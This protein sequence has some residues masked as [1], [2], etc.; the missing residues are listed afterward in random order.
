MTARRRLRRWHRRIGVVSAV[1]VLGL[2]VTGLLLNHAPS[3]ELDRSRVGLSWVLDRYGVDIEPPARGYAVD[4]HWLSVCGGELF[5]DD[6]PV[7]D[8]ASLSGGVS[9]DGL[10]VA[11]APAVL[12]LLD[13]QGGV[14]ERLALDALPGRISAIAQVDSGIALRVDGRWL[15]SDVDLLGWEPVAAPPRPAEARPLPADLASRITQRSRARQLSWERVL[16]DVHSGR[17]FGPFGPWVLD[18]FAVLLGFLALSGFWLWS[19]QR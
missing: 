7:T 3:L 8:L 5:L 11:A 17:F 9:L 1:V 16:L 19:R 6:R 15:A 2:V 14:I 4:G 10:I 12:V 18:F 13:G